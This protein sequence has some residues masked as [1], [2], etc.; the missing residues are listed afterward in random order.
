[1]VT[2]LCACLLLDGLA[3][4]RVMPSRVGVTVADE[5]VFSDDNS[6]CYCDDSSPRAELDAGV[7][8]EMA[9]RLS[10]PVMETLPNSKRGQSDFKILCWCL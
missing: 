5:C 8:P 10:E 6:T 4:T 2:V 3:V 7:L 9:G 1:M